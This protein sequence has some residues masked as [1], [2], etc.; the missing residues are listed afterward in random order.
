MSAL[1][2]P[3]KKEKQDTHACATGRHWHICLQT[4]AYHTININKNP[5]FHLYIPGL[6]RRTHALTFERH[7]D[8]RPKDLFLFCLSATND[9]AFRWKMG[10]SSFV[11]A[12]CWC[13]GAWIIV[14]IVRAVR[15]FCGG[16]CDRS[17]ISIDFTPPKAWLW[18]I[19]LLSSPHRQ[20]IREIREVAKNI[21]Y[22]C[23][24]G[25]FFLASHNDEMCAERNGITWHYVFALWSR[26]VTIG[27]YSWTKMAGGN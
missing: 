15:A 11:H 20:C 13:C 7:R 23:G 21:I 24:F 27:W 5:A 1:V 9:F 10:F 18:R 14:C 25:L 26:D 8:Y 17:I 6:P 3:Q 2:I 12:V 22:E 19:A 4:I 16:W